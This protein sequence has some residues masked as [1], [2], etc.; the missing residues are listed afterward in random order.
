MVE[1]KAVML[2]CECDGESDQAA[3]VAAAVRTGWRK[4]RLGGG[5]AREACTQTQADGGRRRAM[6]MEDER[7]L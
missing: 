6:G 7:L 5:D 4:L 1:V 2:E 3:P